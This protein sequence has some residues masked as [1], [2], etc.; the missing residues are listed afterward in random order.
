MSGSVAPQNVEPGIF[1]VG[2]AYDGHGT[3]KQHMR[4]SGGF[5]IWQ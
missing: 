1:F 5:H 2:Y 4:F 3:G